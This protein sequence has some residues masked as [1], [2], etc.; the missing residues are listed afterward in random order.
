MSSHSNRQNPARHWSDA[1]P[2]LSAAA[3]ALL[4]GLAC[5]RTPVAE[6]TTAA[7]GG[8]Q[9]GAVQA[10]TAKVAPV[11]ATGP[12]GAPKGATS[13]IPGTPVEIGGTSKSGKLAAKLR[14]TVPQ[15]NEMFSVDALVS[16][17][18]GSVLPA[19]ATVT[20]DATMPEHR[21]GMMTDPETKLAT[22]GKWRTEGMRLHMQGNWM[23]HVKVTSAQ[24]TDE[25]ELP[26]VQPPEAAPGL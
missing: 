14:F 23:F 22:P 26:F 18:D 12:A 25:V 7:T 6:S 17:Q 9:A 3:L 4:V 13:P 20:L 11:P 1:A 8:G 19:D 5:Q 16:L 10:V 15:V 2:A 24:S 21:H